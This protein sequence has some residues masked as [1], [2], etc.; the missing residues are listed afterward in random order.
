MWTHWSSSGEAETLYIII[1]III[2]IIKLYL[3]S[4]FHAGNI[5]GY[6]RVR[7]LIPTKLYKLYSQDTL[8]AFMQSRV[9][10]TTHGPQIQMKM[11]AIM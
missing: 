2:I 1:I 10:K 4:T 8:V 11:Y 7:I 9:G 5:T 3:Y 6:Y